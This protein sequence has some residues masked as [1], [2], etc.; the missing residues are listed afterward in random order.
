MI[1]DVAGRVRNVQVAVSKPLIPLFE[2]ISNSLDAIEDAGERNGRIEIEVIRDPDAL[3]TTAKSSTDRQLAEI[4]G[5]AVSDNG[6]G[7]DDENYREFNKSD[8][9]HKAERGGK[10]IGRFTW[11]VAFERVEIDSVYRHDGIMRQRH[12]VFSLGEGGVGHE[13]SL[14]NID[15]PRKTT[16]RLMLFKEKYRKQC[17]KRIDTLAAYIVEEFLD[18]FLG[19]SC[20]K[21]ILR[22]DTAERTVDLDDFYEKE[23]VLYSKHEALPIKNIPFEIVHVQLSSTHI[24]EHRLYLCAKDRAVVCEKLTGIAN[25]GPRFTAMDNREFVYA[26]YV[27]SSILDQTVNTDRTGFTLAEDTKGLLADDVAM[28]DIRNAIKERCREYL[29]PYT[30]PI[31]RQKRDRIRRFIQQDGVMYR[32]VL[33]HLE[34]RFD[35]IEPEASDGEVD[36]KLYEAYSEFQVKLRREGQELLK[37]VVSE[38]SEFAE[39]EERFHEYFASVSDVNRADLARYVCHRKAI[40]EF[41]RQQLGRKADGT[42]RLED[43]IHSIIFPMGKTSDEVFYEEHNLWLIDERLAFH[44]FLSSDKPLKNAK[45]LETSSRK[46]PDIIVFDKAMAFSETPDVPFTSVTIIEFKKPQRK[47]YSEKEN[48]FSQVADYIRDIRAGKA[49]LSDGRPMP[50]AVNLPIYC[51]I[52]CDITQRLEHWAQNFELEWTPDRLGFF[53]YK[54]PFGAYCEVISYAKL[55]SDAQKRNQA[56]FEKL[57]LAR[58]LGPVT[59]NIVVSSSGEK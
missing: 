3:F 32:P 51:Y 10:G 49:V 57:G 28:S 29:A 53:G 14:E 5:F 9:T 15:T 35:E 12:F 13:S 33:D 19:D 40:I 48:P 11:L 43:R 34:H 6:T 45:V 8:T 58:S 50:I 2:A 22:D 41:L 42:Y 20:P 23:M 52:I 56:F 37:A 18:V 7:F 38:D 30:E 55:V 31:R 46:E 27:N 1:T 24:P 39:F 21:M 25:M 4:T 17:P 44:E 47:E 36:L 54:K 16:V 59:G 26:A